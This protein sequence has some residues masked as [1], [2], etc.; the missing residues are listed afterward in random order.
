MVRSTYLDDDKAGSLV[1]R[2]HGQANNGAADQVE[3]PVLLDVVLKE[4]VDLVRTFLVRM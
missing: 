1:P 2:A 4:V 3:A